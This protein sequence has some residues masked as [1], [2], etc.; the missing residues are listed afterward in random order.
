MGIGELYVASYE[1]IRVIRAEELD[2][3]T[4]Q[5]QNSPE[6]TVVESPQLWMGRVTDEPGKDS[7]SH[8]HGEAE[9]TGYILSGHMRIYYGEQYEEYVDLGPGDFVYVPPFVPHIERNRSDTE[10]VV[11]IT[12]RNP[13]NIVVNLDDNKAY[14]DTLNHLSNSEITVVRASGLDTATN[15]I[16]NLPMRTGVEAPHLWMGRVTSAPGKE[17]GAHHHGEAETGVYILSGHT[18]IFYG[19]RY[20]EYVELGPG[21][22][23]YVPPF[24]PH[25]E[26]NISDTEPVEFVAVRNPKNILVNL[27]GKLE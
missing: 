7:G 9:T 1:A 4:A 3:G 25:I 11:F 19:E 6:Q 12:A 18:R 27:E 21:D 5:T 10:P 16:E 8:H 14:Q 2:S 20:K 24:I 26:K 23:M 17:S 22:F 15:Q 13:G